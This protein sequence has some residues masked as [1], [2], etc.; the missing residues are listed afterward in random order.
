MDNPDVIVT[1]LIPMQTAVIEAIISVCKYIFFNKT[2][3][4]N[5]SLNVLLSTIAVLAATLSICNTVLDL[6]KTQ[7]I[8]GSFALVTQAAILMSAQLKNV[9]READE[10]KAKE[11]EQINA[12]IDSEL[13]Q[14]T[15]SEQINSAPAQETAR[16]QIN[17]APAHRITIEHAQ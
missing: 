2:T 7:K 13:K 9:V 6:N 1:L 5:G 10:E 3:K 16:E 12:K 4:K 17:S 14:E 8:A 15:A 11:K